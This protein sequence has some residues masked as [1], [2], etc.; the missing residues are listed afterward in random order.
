[1]LKFIARQWRGEAPF[2]ISVFVFSFLLPW[3]LVIGSLS[4]LG[5]FTMDQTPTASMI[6][7]AIVFGLIAVV[8]IW[9]FIGTWRVASKLKSPG[10]AWPTR[11][12]GRTVATAGLLVS[13][14]AF[15]T[16]PG[17]MARYYSEATDADW[18]GQQGHSV[19]VE[20]D[21]IVISGHMSW[22]LYDE[23]VAALKENPDVRTVVLD[24]PGGHYAVGLLMGRLIRQKSLD[25]LTT[26]MCGS[27][28]VYAFLG[29]QQRLLQ[30]GAQLGFHAMA[31]NTEAVLTRMQGHAT[32]VLKAAD[33]PDEFIA[34]AFATPSDDVWYPTVEELR[35]SNVI[36]DVVG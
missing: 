22:G 23:F 26:Q 20:D 4:W 13:A 8:A 3:A 11:W 17:A 15:A 7:A 19:T 31:G 35:D 10:R 1:M 21:Q 5:V 27:A 12:L 33:V 6:A 2:W 32:E 34:R 25:T 18:I 29:G 14:A 36:T 24:S 28:C 30:E 9:Q 16:M